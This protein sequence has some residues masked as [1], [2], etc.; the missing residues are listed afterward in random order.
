MKFVS[1]ISLDRFSLAA[2]FSKTSF[3]AL[4]LFICNNL[5]EIEVYPSTRRGHMTDVCPE[6][7]SPV[8]R[9]NPE[10]GNKCPIY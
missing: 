3:F 1:H 10:D 5:N 4:T 8:M 2:L 9:A 6:S 7:L